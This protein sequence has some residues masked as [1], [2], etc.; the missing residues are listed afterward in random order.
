[1]QINE[2]D[3]FKKNAE[4]ARGAHRPFFSGEVQMYLVR[5]RSCNA[6]DEDSPILVN[7]PSFRNSQ[8]FPLHPSLRYLHIRSLPSSRWPH[9]RS[10]RR[11]VHLEVPS[12]DATD[13]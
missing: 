3:P 10:W 4:T 8:K 1:M 12:F 6:D 9:R 7:L 13:P 2:E 5:E 11:T